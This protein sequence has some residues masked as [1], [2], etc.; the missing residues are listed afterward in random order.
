MLIQESLHHD[1][2][3]SETLFHRGLIFE[4]SDKLEKA[5][6]DYLQSSHLGSKLRKSY[7]LRHLS[8]IAQKQ[9]NYS[10]AIDYMKQALDLRQEIEFIFGEAYIHWGLGVLYEKF[11]KTKLALKYYWNINLHFLIG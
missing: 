5:K 7:A 11:E 6:Q 3:L 10:A 9:T 1:E 8:N 4:L 2:L